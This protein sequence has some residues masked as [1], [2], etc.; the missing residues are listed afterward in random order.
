MA[1]RGGDRALACPPRPRA[2][3]APAARRP[4]RA[5]GPPAGCLRARRAT[6]RARR[7]ARAPCV[8]RASR[9]SRSRS[10]A[11]AAASASSAARPS[12]AGVGPDGTWRDSTSSSCSSASRRCADSWRT[13]TRCAAPRSVSSASRPPP[14]STRL[15]VGAACEHVVELDLQLGLRAALDRADARPALLG[16]DLEPC[17]LAGGALRVGRSVAR[18][19]FEL[20]RG[21][22]IVRAC[23][24]ELGAD[25]GSERA[26][27]LAAKLQ[28][29]AAA[30][31][32][33]ERGSRL[34]ARAR[35]IGQLLFGLLALGDEGGDLL[36]EHA[37][38]L[39]GRDAAAL[40]L[41][42]T[43]GE[44]H[45]VERRDR[46]LQAGDL[47]AEL[48]GALGR[49][50]LQGKRAQ[51]LLDLVLEVA[52]ALDLDADA[53]ELQLGAV[54]AA[55][56]AAEPGRLLDQ[57]APLL[58]LRVEHR[59][60]AALRDDRAQA[61]AE[62]DVGEQ[63]DQVDAA[64]GSLVDEVLPLAAALQAAG[65]GDLAST[66]APATR[67]R[68]CRRAGRPR[69]GRSAGGPP[70]LRRGRRRASRR[71]ARR[72]S[73]SRSPRGSSRRRSTCRSRSARPRPRL[74]ARAGS[75]PGPR[76]T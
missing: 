73:S 1:E 32:P 5:R 34:L 76:T 35:G 26:R 39:G 3:A 17:A 70:S 15:G 49:G 48:L 11:R 42:A 4:R 7:G 43:L 58:R 33:V 50:R 36:V 66:A 21:G 53:R 29:L 9:S 2:A 12:S 52:G 10:A 46:R 14:V 59:L 74:P 62:A 57:L 19:R 38:L 23:S 45:E 68:R 61:A 69:R 63:L 18:G 71:A 41:R 16:L 8:T 67:R 75:R 56:E 20:D 6:A 27:R 64:D 24:L 25:R 60:D 22:R 55:L 47:D 44:A 72:G 31:Q 13:P 65:D 28:A 30:A 51:P 40:C 54:L 37:A